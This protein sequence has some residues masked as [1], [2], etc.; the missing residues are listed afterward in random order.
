[1]AFQGIMAKRPCTTSF[2]L[3]RWDTVV[4]AVGVGGGD[5][6]CCVMTAIATHFPFHTRRAAGAGRRAERAGLHVRKRTKQLI[7]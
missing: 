4:A 5:D 1:M 6:I 2:L 3:H 7:N